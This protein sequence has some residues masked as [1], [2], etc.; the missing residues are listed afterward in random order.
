MTNLNVSG[1]IVI[2]ANNVTINNTKVVQTGDIW[3]IGL[4]SGVQNATIEN[5]TI[6]GTT[7]TGPSRLQVGLKDV[8]GNASGTQILRDDFSDCGSCIQMSNG[9]VEDSYIHDFGYTSGDHTNGISVGGGDP[10]PM[11]IQH[12]TILNQRD[13][14]DAVALFQDFGDES[15]KTVDDNLFAGGSYTLYGGGPNAACSGFNRTSGCYGPSDHIVVTNN[16]FSRLF[17]PNGGTF[18]YVSA[19]NPSGA[20]NVWSGE[21]V[22]RHWR[23]GARSVTTRLDRLASSWSAGQTPHRTQRR[24][25][26]R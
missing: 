11:L 19:F 23:H 15:N 10:K 16:H 22:G 6:T 8:Y 24:R 9:T 5:S 26:W 1:T 25:A 4:A 17:F 7:D 14:T 2:K 12:N 3:A 13:Q 21:C 18:G 20:G